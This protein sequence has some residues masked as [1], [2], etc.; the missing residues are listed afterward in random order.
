MERETRTVTEMVDHASHVFSPQL[1]VLDAIHC[2]VSP[3]KDEEWQHNQRE[4][5]GGEWTNV[6]DAEGK[7]AG[8]KRYNR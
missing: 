4:P 1:S 6:R 7:R 3:T 2:H 8:T 5:C